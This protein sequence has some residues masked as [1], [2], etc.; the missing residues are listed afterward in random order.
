MSL[1]R[2]VKRV[3][4]A[5]HT[6]IGSGEPAP[7][8]YLLVPAETNGESVVTEWEA[9]EVSQRR[10]ERLHGRIEEEVIEQ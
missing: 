1:V 5:N 8:Y 3:G 6:D 9:H 4:G 7:E 2:L 10:L